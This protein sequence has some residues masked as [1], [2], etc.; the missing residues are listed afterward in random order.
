[1][2]KTR[3]VISRLK[4]VWQAAKNPTEEELARNDRNYS[5][6]GTARRPS[7][8]Q[9]QVHEPSQQLEEFRLLVGSMCS[10]G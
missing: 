8:W 3:N 5:V 2:D 4:S 7:Q 9:E 6:A 10:A 1:M